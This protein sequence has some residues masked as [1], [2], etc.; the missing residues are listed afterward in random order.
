MMSPPTRRCGLRCHPV[1]DGCKGPSFAFAGLFLLVATLWMSVPVTS[2]PVVFDKKRH[3]LGDLKPQPLSNAERAWNQNRDQDE[4]YTTE[5]VPVLPTD[6]SNQAAA[7]RATE[8]QEQIS[9]SAVATDNDRSA[10]FPDDNIAQHDHNNETDHT[11][12][13]S[14]GLDTDLSDCPEIPHRIIFTYKKDLLAI[15]MSA[16]PDFDLFEK[17]L[18]DNMLNTIR[19]FSDAWESSPPVVCMD[20]SA[21]REAIR[22]VQPELVTHFDNEK[23]GMYK[24]DICRVAA[25]YL[26][27]GYYFDIDLQVIEAPPVTLANRFVTALTP[28]KKEF[29]QALL[30][31]SPRHPALKLACETMLDYYRNHMGRAF[32]G[33]AHMGTETLRVAYEKWSSNTFNI[34]FLGPLDI[35]LKEEQTWLLQEQHLDQANEN[36]VYD[37]LDRQEVDENVEDGRC[38]FVV[39]GKTHGC[40]H[41]VLRACHCNHGFARWPL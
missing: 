2:V 32:M 16:H 5:R 3:S 36:H 38:N 25:L 27:G 12:S 23:Q 29:F 41:V 17:V 13:Q 10:K 1:H 30:F 4:D 15:G 31:A 11:Q 35:T 14:C 6:T 34:N 28:D 37:H 24:A 21:C 39:H 40:T 33:G 19:K 18:Y 7:E 26:T 8:L 9:D 20:D 22:A